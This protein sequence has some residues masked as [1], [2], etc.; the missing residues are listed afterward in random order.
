MRSRDLVR[1]AARNAF[2]SR[3]RTTLTV[4]SLFVGAFT[5]TLTTALGAGVNDYV[6]RQVATLSSGEL[7][8]VAPAVSVDSGEGPAEY[9]PDGR[10]DGTLGN[11]LAAVA[12]LNQQD[13]DAIAGIE[14]VLRVEPIS[15]ISV[16][17]I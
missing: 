9:D 11:P 15:Q 12:Q 1:G 2:R 4:L 8:L 3:L 13:L 10:Q 5:L 6:E 17:W 14:G 16:E 7:L